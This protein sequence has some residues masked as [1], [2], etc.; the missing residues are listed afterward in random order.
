MGAGFSDCRE[1]AQPSFSACPLTRANNF[2]DPGNPVLTLPSG[3]R[4]FTRDLN[5]AKPLL[6]APP[7]EARVSKIAVSLMF[8]CAIVLAS[9]PSFARA[10]GRSAPPP[11]PAAAQPAKSAAVKPAAVQPSKARTG[12]A[13]KSTATEPQKPFAAAPRPG[14][15]TFVNISVRPSAAAAGAGSAHRAMQGGDEY[16][17]PLHFDPA[18]A[19][20]GQ[21]S[22]ARMENKAASTDPAAQAAMATPRLHE[23]AP[24][25][26]A[27]ARLGQPPKPAAAGEPHAISVCYVQRSGECRPF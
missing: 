19:A 1:R 7:R 2:I 11:K 4:K 27:S 3:C 18:F 21:G 24:I 23:M 17:G 10:R 6:T 22:P 5:Q 25:E 12:Q 9:D 8:G 20:A 14:G 26:A 15:S 13:S 16:A